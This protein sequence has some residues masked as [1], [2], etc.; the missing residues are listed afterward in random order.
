M[1]ALLSA[2]ALCLPLVAGATEV[3][4]VRPVGVGLGLGEPVRVD[5]RA[6][7]T[8]YRT[9]SLRA[10]AGWDLKGLEGA[11]PRVEA[12]V[13]LQPLELADTPTVEVPL[14][15]GVGVVA[16]RW[17]R[18]KDDDPWR[19]RPGWLAPRLS[20]GVDADLSDLPLQLYAE[21]AAEVLVKPRVHPG[22]GLAVGVR[23]YP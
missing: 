4:S 20:V 23:F 7:L 17:L 18:G 21:A 15:L 11:G 5:V 3:G 10:G 9:W 19:H 16:G 1:R 2:L 6:Y 8:R 13:L 22:L 14:H 12:E